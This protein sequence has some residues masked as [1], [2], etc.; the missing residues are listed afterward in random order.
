ML[1]VAPVAVVF[2]AWDLAAIAVGDWRYDPAQLVGVWLPGGLPLEELVFFLVV[3]CCAI[4]GFE[5]VRRVTGWAAGDEPAP[6]SGAPGCATPWGRHPV[7]S[8]PSGWISR[9]CGPA[10]SGAR[11]SGRRTRSCWSFS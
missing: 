4:L 10:W 8:V 11:C 7:C 1:T 2:C 9:S 6:G 3:P 5:A